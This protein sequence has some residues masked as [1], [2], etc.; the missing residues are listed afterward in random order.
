MDLNLKN[1]VIKTRS[2]VHSCSFHP[3]SKYEKMTGPCAAL[4]EQ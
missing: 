1:G 3:L 4:T 2:D